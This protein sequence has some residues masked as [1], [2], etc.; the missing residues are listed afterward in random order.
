MCRLTTLSM[1][2]VPPP[3]FEMGGSGGSRRVSYEYETPLTLPFPVISCA[4]TTPVKQK[5]SKRLRRFIIAPDNSWPELG[6]GLE[7]RKTAYRL[8][9]TAKSLEC[10]H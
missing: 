7:L 4:E 8:L 6:H 3:F 9:R 2:S 5:T 1:V 10:Q